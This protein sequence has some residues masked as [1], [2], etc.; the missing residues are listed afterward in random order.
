MFPPGFYV[1]LYSLFVTGT[2]QSRNLSKNYLDLKPEN[3]DL[4]CLSPSRLTPHPSP[5]IEGQK[6]NR[7]SGEIYDRAFR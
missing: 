5:L 6:E 2:D 7:P 3:R 1:N 4:A